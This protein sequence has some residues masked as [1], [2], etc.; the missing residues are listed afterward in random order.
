MIVTSVPFHPIYVSTQ[1]SKIVSDSRLCYDC[2]I[3]TFPSTQPSM[4][5]PIVGYVMTVTA[6][7]TFPS[8]QPSMIIPVVGYVNYCYSCTFPS[9]QPSMIVPVVSYVMAV[10][11]VHFRLHSQA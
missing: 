3:C 8:A 4:K 1:P 11:S 6:A 9:A 2:Y 10:T 7:C 5:V